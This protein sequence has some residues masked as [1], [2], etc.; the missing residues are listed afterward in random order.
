MKTSLIKVGQGFGTAGAVYIR[1]KGNQ[2]RVEY[3]NGHVFQWLDGY[4]DKKALV[5]LI[6]AAVRVPCKPHEVKQTG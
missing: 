5:S 4:Y 2:A 6:Q 3:D 1:T